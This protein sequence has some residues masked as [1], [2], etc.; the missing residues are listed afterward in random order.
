MSQR[1][2]DNLSNEGRDRRDERWRLSRRAGVYVDEF[3]VCDFGSI[4]PCG[5]AP[6]SDGFLCRRKN[7]CLKEAETSMNAKSRSFEHEHVSIPL[8]P[9]HLRKKIHKE[10]YDALLTKVGLVPSDAQAVGVALRDHK[11]PHVRIEY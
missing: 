10:I 8:E 5:G 1:I 2:R 4:G 11:I 6:F 3:S 7:Q 9:E